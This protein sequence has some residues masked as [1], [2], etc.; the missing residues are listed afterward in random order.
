LV[1]N[2]KAQNV[3]SPLEHFGF[4]MGQDYQLANYTETAKFFNKL[5]QSKRVKLVEIGKTEE[6]RPQYMLV[7]SSPENIQKLEEYK[8]IST[9]LA[10]AQG[11]DSEA[12]KQLAARGKAVVWIDGGLHSTEMVGT[13]QLIQTAY[14]LA[15]STDPEVV[16]ILDNVIVLL[17]HANPDGQELVANWYLQQSDTLARSMDIPT[18]YHKY[19]G[20]DNNR[21]F[22]MNNLKETQN[23]SRQ[24]FVEWVPQIMYNHHQSAPEGAVVAEPPYIHPFNYTLDRLLMS[25]ID[26]VGASMINRL[27]VEDKPGF[28]RLKGSPFSTWYNGGLRT[29]TYFHN[30]IGILSEIIGHPTPMAIPLVPERLLPNGNTPNPVTP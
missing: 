18:L 9:K 10:F 28:T 7:I 2:P 8:E 1:F 23:L 24:L 5:T 27:N 6:D 12:A 22:Y 13:H 11:L 25:S 15:S 16:E 26:A 21:D 17:V 30:M 20:H 19:V 4:F 3:P 14:E 29:T